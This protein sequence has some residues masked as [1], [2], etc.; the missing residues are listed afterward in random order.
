MKLLFFAGGTT[1]TGME[2]ALLSLMERLNAIGH[3]AV[4]IVS[5]WNDGA[6]PPM[7]DAA[8]IEHHE[9]FLGRIYRNN[10]E[11]TRGTLYAL[12]EAAR[13]IRGVVASLAAGLGDFRRGAVAAA[14]LADPAGCPA[15]P[16]SARRA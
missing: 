11:W 2:V 13:D 15:R 5:G 16:L 1:V 14:L 7:L 6:Y 12:R 8:D 9:V 4:A 3:R 10:P